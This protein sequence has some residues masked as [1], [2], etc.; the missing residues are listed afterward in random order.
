MPS[1]PLE[2]NVHGYA[3]SRRCPTD[4][5]DKGGSLRSCLADADGVG[6]AATPTLPISMLLL[7]VVRLAPAPCPRRC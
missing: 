5:G 6:L 7:P 2:S 4:S 3:A 1:L